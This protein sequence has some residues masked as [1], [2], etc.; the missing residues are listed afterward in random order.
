MKL[1]KYILNQI[2]IHTSIL[3]IFLILSGTNDLL[4]VIRHNRETSTTLPHHLIMETAKNI[5]RGILSLHK[6][7]HRYH[8]VSTVLV[9]L[10]EI[11]YERYDNTEVSKKL[12]KAV[13]RKLK[14]YALK[15]KKNTLLANLAAYLDKL[16]SDSQEYAQIWDDGVHLTPYG[17]N[18]M[19]EY[20]YNKISRKK[21]LPTASSDDSNEAVKEYVSRSDWDS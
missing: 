11:K 12:R 13:N 8:H 3:H 10:P 17:Y 20:I 14:K 16:G 7:C 6:M 15:H 5:S 1:I 4:H 21:Y 9:T 2:L 19:G 18:R